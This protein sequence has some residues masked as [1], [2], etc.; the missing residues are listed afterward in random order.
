MKLKQ[1]IEKIRV[2]MLRAPLLIKVGGVLVAVFLVLWLSATILGPKRQPA[3]I[4][5]TQMLKM[6]PTEEVT[7]PS[8]YATDGAILKIE[9]DLRE[10]EQKLQAEDLKENELRPPI[11]DF[12]VAFE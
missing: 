6:T 11:L 7:R 4:L 12:E 9:G 2:R 1:Q 10:L 3:S 5:P 8:A